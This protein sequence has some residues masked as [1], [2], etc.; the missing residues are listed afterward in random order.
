MKVPSSP[1]VSETTANPLVQQQRQP[2]QQELKDQLYK[3]PPGASVKSFSHGKQHDPTARRICLSFTAVPSELRQLQA[4]VNRMLGQ[5]NSTLDCVHL[6]IPLEALRFKGDYPRTEVLLDM[7]PD[8]RIVLHRLSQDYGPLTRYIGPLAYEQHPETALIVFDVDSTKIT[9]GTRDLR[10][11]LEGLTK[12]DPHAVWCYQGEDFRYEAQQK[13]MV[14]HWDTYPKYGIQT[15]TNTT[16]PTNTDQLP[17]PQHEIL[18]RP[19]SYGLVW[20]Q[21]FFCRAAGGLLFQPRHFRD[22]WYN[23]TNYHESC[24]YDD[25]RWLGFQLERQQIIVNALVPPEELEHQLRE[26]PR[27]IVLPFSGRKR[28]TAATMPISKNEE[29]TKEFPI[30]NLQRRRRLG[31]LTATTQRLR[32]DQ[33][34]PIVWLE[35]HPNSFPLARV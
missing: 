13:R 27:K 11:L 19:P 22:F 20:N 16:G 23:Q 35:R 25:D 17:Q 32:S 26:K 33:T 2:Q 15:T 18:Q 12:V 24:L 10:P 29:K 30:Q 34:C 6:S 21:A 14:P 1:S 9:S 31:T 8:E 28:D 4:L 3:L 5:Y 7:F